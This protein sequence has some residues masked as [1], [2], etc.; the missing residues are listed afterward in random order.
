[1]STVPLLVCDRLAVARGTRTV[2]HDV[3]F[4]L[5]PGE[6]VAVLGPN[7]S[8]KST[9]LDAL[10]G[11][12]SPRGGSIERH[13]RV[14]VALQSADLARGSVLA[15]VMAALAWWG[16]PRSERRPRAREALGLMGA[17]HLADRPATAL[18][19]GERRRVHLARTIAVRPDVL[20]LDEP[21]AGLDGAVRAALLQ[22]TGA[23][24]RTAARASLVVVHDRSEA[25]AL[26][27]RLIILL[28]GTI[29][30]QGPPRD[31]LDSPPTVEVARF[32]GFDGTLVQADGRRLLT[33][34][35]HV[36]LDADG[37]LGAEVTQMIP[38][39]D[40]IRLGLALEHGELTCLAA[41]PS[42]RH[43]DRVRI[44]ITGGVS[45]PAAGDPAGGPAQEP[46][47]APGAA[48]CESP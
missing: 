31:L 48:Q 42:P 20:M 34:P 19:G 33:R 13:G 11:V 36:V 41:L 16:V 5:S 23:A 44:R 27:D 47:V 12:L 24:L 15:N 45:F 21:F 14:A 25:W 37:P 32:L 8:G 29:A 7:G 9:L 4:G 2:L 17:D 18:S 26:A 39:E 22:D 35:Q 28:D 43:G 30:A 38:T 46:T 40:G 6:V 10:G 3:S 1:V